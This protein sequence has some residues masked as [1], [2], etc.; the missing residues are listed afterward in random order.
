MVSDQR[1]RVELLLLGPGRRAEQ[2]V[3]RALAALLDGDGE[4]G[5]T[6]LVR[7]GDIVLSTSGTSFDPASKSL[8]PL[9]LVLVEG[10]ALLV[11]EAVAPLP[12]DAARIALDEGVEAVDAAAALLAS[13]AFAS[14]S[15]RLPRSKFWSCRAWV[16]SCTIVDSTAGVIS[17]PRIRSRSSS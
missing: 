1:P 16:S 10:A 9:R 11:G 17:V 13:S 7:R 8:A 15:K 2:V 6:E 4:Q 14:S 5:L 3:D 12:L